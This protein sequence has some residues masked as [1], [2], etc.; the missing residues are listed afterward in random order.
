M[1]HPA[2]AM[3]IVESEQDLFCDLFDEGHGHALAL[4][5]TDEPEQVLA[6]HF[7]NHAY[8]RPVGPTMPKV[9]EEAN[10]MPPTG[11]I[12]V[13]RDYALQEFDLVEGSLR[14]ALRRLDDFEGNMTVESVVYD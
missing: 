3:H 5:P 12:M 14:V 4:V 13:R 6:E 2:A 8:V 1:N 10:Y 11:M 9:V 7:K